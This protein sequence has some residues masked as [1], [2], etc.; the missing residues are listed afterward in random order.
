[1]FDVSCAF[2]VPRHFRGRA[3]MQEA[4]S[5]AEVQEAAE[6]QKQFG[7]KTAEEARKWV[8]DLDPS[9]LRLNVMFSGKSIPIEPDLAARLDL[10]ERL[11][12]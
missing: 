7:F 6:D 1:M 8:D 5:L 10:A 11:L 2:N 4:K 3:K 12:E 9:S